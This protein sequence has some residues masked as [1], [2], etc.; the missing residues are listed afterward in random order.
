[1][2]DFHFAQPVWFWMLA[3]L[4]LLVALF[5]TAERRRRAALDR[6]LAARLQPRLAGSVSIPRRR[7][8]F[9]LCALG[10]ALAFLAAARPQWGFAWEERKERG[11]DVLIA[12]DTSRSMLATDLLPNRLT[13]AKLAVQDLMAALEGERVG[14]LAFAGTSFLQAPLTADFTAVRDAL[15]EIDTD[16]IPLGG[17]NLA[18]AITAASDALG[19]GE[20]D[21]RALVI[22]TD[23]EELEEDAVA[24]ARANKDKFRI[25][26]VG[27]GS[28]EGSL[29]PVTDKQGGTDFVRDERGQYV[30]T[31]LDERRLREIAEASGGFYL[32]LQ[33]GPADMNRIVR[34]GLSK[35]KEHKG[36][37]RFSKQP[38]ERYQW[39]L[40]AS[41]A[42]IIASLLLGERR[43][44]I[45]R[46]AAALLL[47]SALPAQA[48]HPGI[49]K[50]ERKDYK[51]SLGEFERE[52]V[53]R[54]VPEVQFD[55]GAAAFE[56][57]D[58]G[59]AAD[60]FSRALGTANPALKNRAAYNLANTLARRGVAQEKK[61]DKLSD[62]R[63]AVR[64]Y[65]E[66]L[67]SDAKHADAKH[68]RDIVAKLVQELEQEEKKKEEQD[69]KDEKKDDKKDEK[70]DDKQ[71]KQDQDKKDSS[72]DGGG[73]QKKPDAGNDEKKKDK[74]DQNSSKGKQDDKDKQDS[75]DKGDAKKPDESGQ[76][77]PKENKGGKPDSEKQKKSEKPDDKKDGQPEP[78]PSEAEKQKSGEVKAA[79]PSQEEKERKEQEA[80]AAEVAAAAKEGRM[81]EK[82]AR[83]IF[84]ALK[85]VDRRIRVLSPD[86]AKPRN[87][88]APFKNW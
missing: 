7:M 40:A 36:D 52:L 11:R 61:E 38:I 73:E 9:A 41:M 54:D 85:K 19:K 1:M 28:A 56:L 49:E 72:K 42:C 43:R 68:N 39:P 24:A 8:G 71:D 5:F 22:F 80:E 87:P 78:Q 76:P 84:E 2:K 3:T 63:D 70:K 53:R 6:L 62:L 26:T 14:L 79:N 55:A 21:T 10:I 59:R 32:L 13:R 51:G 48:A 20:G 30:K 47:L 34:E 50:F 33:N 75:N 12:L 4:P 25:F 29:I 35:M 44:T 15:Q 82:D 17:T 23:G 88:N 27:L 58:Y 37:A 45:A 69:K 18:G 77:D 64:Q 81:T 65:D 66:V 83:Q 46:A 31:R 57:G 74:Q 16:I 60:A 86:D 67:N